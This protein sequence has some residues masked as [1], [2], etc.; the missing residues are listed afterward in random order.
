MS[1]SITTSTGT[2]ITITDDGTAIVSN[3]KIAENMKI[4]HAGD[5]APGKRTKYSLM[6]AKLTSAIA[7][8]VGKPYVIG[9]IGE[10]SRKTYNIGLDEKEYQWLDENW[11]Q[12]ESE[13]EKWAK[14][15]PA[16][17]KAR[18][19]YMRMFD[20]WETKFEQAMESED[21]SSFAPAKPTATEPALDADGAAYLKIDK[22]A[23]SSWI[24]ENMI[25]KAAIK[26]VLSGEKTLQEALAE[27]NEKMTAALAKVD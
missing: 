9:A 19:E 20:E 13:A 21:K 15:I 17:A 7:K 6:G 2:T 24:D 16:T 22:M 23:K 27:A 14:M 4:A 18:R 3:P 12:E 8:K 10:Q 11:P 1:K 5:T 25:G 26:A